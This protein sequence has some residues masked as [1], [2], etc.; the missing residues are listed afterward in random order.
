M[1]WT[2]E[3][4][5]RLIVDGVTIRLQPPVRIW[6]CAP[7]KVDLQACTDGHGCQEIVASCLRCHLPFCALHVEVHQRRLTVPPDAWKSVA[8]KLRAN[9]LKAA[10]LPMTHPIRFNNA[11]ALATIEVNGRLVSRRPP[12]RIEFCRVP[13]TGNTDA[14]CG[15]RA[16][17]CTQG[18]HEC[19][20]CRFTYCDRHFLNHAY[21][22]IAP[23]DV[24]LDVVERFQEEMEKCAQRRG[25]GLIRVR[26][27]RF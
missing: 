17:T 16:K 8:K 9:L 5:T 12:A 21:H 25:R 19:Y 22:A 10:G 14:A 23:R 11:P 15:H 26:V 6:Y 3:R 2:P 7:A 27:P 18:S 20:R 4:K 24:W 13:H 1:L